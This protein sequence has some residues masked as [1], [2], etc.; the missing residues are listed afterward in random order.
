MAT[1]LQFLG[2][3]RNVTGSRYLLDSEGTSVLIDCGLY[4]ERQFRHRNWESFTFDPSDIDAV[5]LTHAHV[6]H[7]G[8][9]P[10]LVSEGFS[11]PIFCTEATAELL[12][13]VLLDA[14]HIQEEDAKHKRRR[15]EREGRTGPHEVKPLYTRNDAEKCFPLVR[16]VRYGDIVEVAGMITAVFYEAGHILGSSM[17]S[18]EYGKS[19]R[20]ILFSG[21]IGRWD[22]PILRD[23]TLVEEADYVVMESTYGNR[24]HEDPG[25]MD[26]MLADA[27]NW[28]NERD[29]NIVI[30]S[31]AIG[32]TQEVLYRLNELLVD[33]AI[34]H[35]MTFVDS[36]MAVRVTDV[37]RDHKELFDQEAARYEREHQSPFSMPMLKMVSS[38]E[39]SKAINHIRGTA[40][41][42]SASGMCTAGRIKHHLV[43]NISQ[44]EC[45][46]LF[47]GY[48]AHGTLGREIVEG[49]R[50]VRILGTMRT[51]KARIIQL[52]GFSAH[53][54]QNELKKWIAAVK[55]PPKKIFVTHGESETADDFAGLLRNEVSAEVAVPEYA[56]RFDLLA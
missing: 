54:D 5:L 49:N 53:A 36:P 12:K 13:I 46:I 9:L 43:H 18:V 32:R 8:L 6:D 25:D 26:E 39:E 7:C 20:R 23:P 48:Q 44:K 21:D 33:D 45:V 47:V 56:E 4:Q 37:F 40:V 10:K 17:I 14:A 11:G 1:S 35:V 50:S 55:N 30:P 2:A 41:I 15:H 42:I 51:V 22:K 19:R 28:A 27:V 24:T 16:S 38:V 31:F 52:H 34:P 29:G 3:T